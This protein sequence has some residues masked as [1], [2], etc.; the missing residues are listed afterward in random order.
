M[1]YATC[2]PLSVP[3]ELQVTPG[4]PDDDD[5]EEE[6]NMSD[7]DE[8]PSDM[9][10]HG[11]DITFADIEGLSQEVNQMSGKSKSMIKIFEMILELV[12]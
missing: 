12:T 8:H 3:E 1:K 4:N 9:A 6:F 7:E 11:E 2:Y 5:V 10:Q